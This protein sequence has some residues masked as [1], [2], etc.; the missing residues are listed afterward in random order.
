MSPLLLADLQAALGP[1]TPPAQPLSAAARLAAARDYGCLGGGCGIASALRESVLEEREES[2]R[3]APLP[4]NA[5]S[6]AFVSVC[7][8]PAVALRAAPSLDAPLLGY[9]RTHEVLCL[10]ARRGL[11]ARLHPGVHVYDSDETWLLLTHA[12][13]GRLVRVLDGELGALPEEQALLASG[14][15]SR[16]CRPPP[17]ALPRPCCR[18]LRVVH[19]PHVLVRAAPSLDARVVAYE[20]C[21]A[22]VRLEA[23]IG[24]W[25]RLA[26]EPPVEGVP[27][28][29]RWMLTWHPELGTLLE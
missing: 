10:V 3:G 25:V 14:E 28:Q 7:H 2:R 13:F 8:H 21:G 9:A 5:K 12:Q 20:R 29:E 11:W 15:T 27:A 24:D 18:L 23:V 16:L 26:A 6:H 17:T 1:S 4:E 22:P 19:S